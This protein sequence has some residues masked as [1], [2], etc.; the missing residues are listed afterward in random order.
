MAD[1][2][3]KG[4]FNPPVAGDWFGYELIKYSECSRWLV[5][6]LHPAGML[7]PS[8]SVDMASIGRQHEIERRREHWQAL[9]Q[10]RC[11]A[12]GKKF[13][14]ATGTIIDGS[15]LEA[16]EIYLLAV[17]LWLDV[18][19]RRIAEVLRIHPDTVRNWQLKFQAQ[20]EV[21]SV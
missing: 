9:E 17:L 6:Q 4:Q 5:T 21:A 19:A 18:P 15:K 12:C 13:T 1:L 14:A 11:P 3:G 10:V 20:A 7:C 16:R 2:E 8:C